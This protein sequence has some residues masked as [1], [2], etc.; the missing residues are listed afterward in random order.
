LLPKPLKNDSI[1]SFRCTIHFSVRLALVGYRDFGDALQ[2]EVLDFA[3]SVDAFH[4]F[5]S[6]LT[7]SGGDDEP[8]DVFGGLEKAIALNWSTDG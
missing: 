6:N 1:I 3:D 2:F 4:Q 7:A 8:E 5:C